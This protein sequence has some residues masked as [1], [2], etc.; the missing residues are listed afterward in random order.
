MPGSAIEAKYQN[1]R[2]VADILHDWTSC[3]SF[4]TIFFGWA[5]RFQ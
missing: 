3:L 2:S 1:P 5:Y 4:R